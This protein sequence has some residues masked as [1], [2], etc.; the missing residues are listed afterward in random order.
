MNT[1]PNFYEDGVT[2]LSH[3]WD[4]QTLEEKIDWVLTHEKERIEIAAAAQERYC[5]YTISKNAADY[6]VNHFQGLVSRF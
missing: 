2:Y 6:F 4:L 1:W 5:D 3:D